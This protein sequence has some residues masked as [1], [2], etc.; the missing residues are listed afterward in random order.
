MVL[1]QRGVGWADT[2]TGQRLRKA[3]GEVP[4]CAQT[5][6]PHG[7]RGNVSREDD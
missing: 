4:T 5:V 6:L 3:V 7:H 2:D 1:P